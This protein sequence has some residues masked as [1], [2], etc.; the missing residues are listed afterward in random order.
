MTEFSIKLKAT[1]TLFIILISSNLFALTKLDEVSSINI[2][3]IVPPY[4]SVSVSS[5]ELS[6]E[7]LGTPGDYISA[8]IVTLTVD[9]N[10]SD[11]GVYAQAAD[12]AH[13]DFGVSPLSARRLS[14][15]VNDQAYESLDRK[16][17]FFSG[18][19]KKESRPIE[20]KFKLKTT[21][22]DSPGIYKG[23]V[24]ISFFNNP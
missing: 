9:S 2:S 15:S 10:Q 1:L 21:W 8:N 13:K 6:F 17:V 5:S 14:V 24:T 23:K 18:S 16:V 12:L 20:L 4:T 19:N 11:W 22:S 7:I 3:A